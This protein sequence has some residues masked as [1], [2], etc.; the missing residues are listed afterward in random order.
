MK[1]LLTLLLT[2]LMTMGLCSCG[3]KVKITPSEVSQIKLVEYKDPDG[4]F[5]MSI[6][7]GWEVSAS[8]LPDMYFGIHAYKP[9]E[10]SSPK[11]HVYMQMKVELMLSQQM[12]DFEMRTFG[13]FKQYAMLYDAP[14]N[15]DGTVAGLYANFNDMIDYMVVYEKGYDEFYTPYLNN[16]EV[17]EEYDYN[18][19]L[20][21][22]A[23]DDKIVR[24]TYT[25]VY[26]ETL[27]QGLFTGTIVASPLGKGTYSAYNVNF[28]SAPDSEF[29][30]YEKLLTD[31]FA[32]IKMSDE[33][34]DLVNSNT[35]ASYQTAKEIGESLQATVDECN[36]AWEQR[37][38]TYDIISQKQSDATLGYERVVDNETGE[39]YQAYNGFMDEYDG[40]R[41]ESI[42]D[43]M[44]T[45]PTAGYI[46]K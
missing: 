43:D 28:I 46:E 7:E 45:L 42:S 15:I 21:D 37:N 18:S 25:D 33:F 36:R 4:R 1:K 39:I 14:V 13:G 38:N 16:F 22:Y 24:A 34:V 41:Y 29:I 40:K 32:S 23:L 5:S 6:P 11:Y 27:M 9:E 8:L 44:Y 3:E 26:D 31:I 12:K 35:Q 30:Q 10:D 17:I 19:L 2:L 20:K